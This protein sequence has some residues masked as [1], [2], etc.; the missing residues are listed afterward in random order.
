MA[1]IVL[2]SSCTG[3]GAVKG[4]IG[5]ILDGDEAGAAARM[6]PTYGAASSCNDSGRSN[7]R[8]ENNAYGLSN[9]GEENA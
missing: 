6:E 4:A 5:I 1:E 8:A 7:A 3:V 9:F 2:L